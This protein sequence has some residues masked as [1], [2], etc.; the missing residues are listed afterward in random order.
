MMMAFAQVGGRSSVSLL[1]NEAV[2]ARDR[3]DTNDLQGHPR[4]SRTTTVHPEARTA[5]GHPERFW[6][7]A[8]DLFATVDADGMLHAINPAW[9]R[10]L[11]RSFAELSSVPLTAFLHPDEDAVTQAG[12]VVTSAE[13]LLAARNH[14][15]A[16]TDSMGETSSSARR[17][18]SARRRSVTS[19]PTTDHVRPSD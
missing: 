10:V 14:L 15:A 17:S 19:R 4:R 3:V 16:V 13:S 6:T 18:V 7:L 2:F 11:G 1:S 5:A 8:T 12:V 9:E